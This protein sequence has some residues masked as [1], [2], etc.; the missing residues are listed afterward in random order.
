MA[1]Y[2]VFRLFYS[3]RISPNFEL[4]W[5]EY[6]VVEMRIWCIKIGIVLVLHLSDSDTSLSAQE[7]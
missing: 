4:F 6:Q 5:P 3:F 7:D 1:Q 2:L